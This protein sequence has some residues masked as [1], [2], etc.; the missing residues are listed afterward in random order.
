MVE[1]NFNFLNPEKRT[2]LFFFLRIFRNICFK[3]KEKI[4]DKYFLTSVIIS[5]DWQMPAAVP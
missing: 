1:Q 4:T 2:T 5:E 3:D